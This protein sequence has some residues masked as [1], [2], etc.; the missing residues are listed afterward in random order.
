MKKLAI[1]QACGGPFRTVICTD[2]K[3]AELFKRPGD[4]V[5]E[6]PDGVSA[7][8]HFWTDGA[9]HVRVSPEPSPEV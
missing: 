9:F 7:R 5:V 2:A 8:T 4:Q 6:L 1:V 3:D